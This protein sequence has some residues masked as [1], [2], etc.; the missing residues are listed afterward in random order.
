MLKLCQYLKKAKID[1]FGIATP[2]IFEDG[3]IIGISVKDLSTGQSRTIAKKD[4]KPGIRMGQWRFLESGISFAEKACNPENH[5]GLAL[6]DELGPLEFNGQGLVKTLKSLANGQYP[7]AIIVVRAELVE[8]LYLMI[9]KRPEII[10]VSA[11]SA[12]EVASFFK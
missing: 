6:I 3:K 2:K 1:Y 7:A 9:P 8:K 11:V 4:E 5:N 10:D 12:K